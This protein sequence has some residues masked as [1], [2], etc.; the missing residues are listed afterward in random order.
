MTENEIMIELENIVKH[1][2]YQLDRLI[3]YSVHGFLKPDVFVIELLKIQKQEFARCLQVVPD[4]Y[5]DKIIN[6]M[7][8]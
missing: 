4:C 2:Q 6:H 1:Y 5:K 7:K 8:N 3:A